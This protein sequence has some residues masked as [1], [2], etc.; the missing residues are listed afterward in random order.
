MATGQV[1]GKQSL[2][3]AADPYSRPMTPRSVR[4]RRGIWNLCRVLLFQFSP[5]PMFRWRAML[6][7][8]FGAKLGP[9]CKIYPKAR[10]WAPWNLRCQDL[11]A[12]ADGADIYNPSPIHFGSH[13]IVSEGAYVCGATHLYNEPEFRMVSFPMA[14][15]A[16]A[17]ICARAIVGPGVNVGEGAI[18][19]LGS[20]AKK[21]LE[22]FG[23]YVGSPAKKVKDRERAAV[24][25]TIR[26]ARPS[27]TILE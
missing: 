24:P 6:L 1:N 23:I 19:G 25:E 5:R 15:G 16:H 14:I 17:W 27:E 7:R 10:I 26:E 22:P 21:D 3:V 20:V 12:F 8:L 13:A 9:G 2:Q 18:L 11:V 4:I